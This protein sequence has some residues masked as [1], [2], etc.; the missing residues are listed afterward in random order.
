MRANSSRFSR[1]GYQED[2]KLV[3]FFI[4]GGKLNIDLYFTPW[5][6]LI[7]EKLKKKKV[8]YYNHSDLGLGKRFFFLLVTVIFSVSC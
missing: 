7:L 4:I 8:E 5:K 6:V 2:L 1:Y 3:Y